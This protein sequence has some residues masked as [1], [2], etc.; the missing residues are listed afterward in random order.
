[1][2]NELFN[3]HALLSSLPPGDNNNRNKHQDSLRPCTSFLLTH[4]CCQWL[5]PFAAV[6][7]PAFQG[8]S[9]LCDEP[10]VHTRR[11]YDVVCT[12]NSS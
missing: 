4:A 7:G 6:A 11:S 3:D 8:R 2:A 5:C 9:P 10:C 1:M 12:K